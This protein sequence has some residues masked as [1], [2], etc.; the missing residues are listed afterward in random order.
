MNHAIERP[1]LTPPLASVIIPTYMR[2]ELLRDTI[3]DV[4]RQDYSPIEIIIVDQSP[5]HD[6]L[7][8]EFL[9]SV[10]PLVTYYQLPT[11][12]LPAARNFGIRMSKG[13]V[14]L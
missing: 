4:L 11:P 14:L 6:G 9:E 1:N 7:T 8:A 10:R 13:Q 12:N 2:D 5:S 3:A